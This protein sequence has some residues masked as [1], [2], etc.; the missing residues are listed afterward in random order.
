[1]AQRIYQTIICNA[2]SQK[3]SHFEASHGRKEYGVF[4]ASDWVFCKNAGR[5]MKVLLAW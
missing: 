4:L 5:R 2:A 1:M 3:L